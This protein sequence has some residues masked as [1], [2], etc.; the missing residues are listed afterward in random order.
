MLLQ[1]LPALLVLQVM[2]GEHG[3]KSVRIGQLK[4]SG[5]GHQ[6]SEGVSLLRICKVPLESAA[7]I[8]AYH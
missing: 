2:H 3:Q 4:E 1:V 8:L 6:E 7:A 5:E